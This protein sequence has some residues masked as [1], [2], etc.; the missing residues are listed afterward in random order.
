MAPDASG[1]VS[2]VVG[3]TA[4]RDDWNMGRDSATV[5]S[6]RRRPAANSAPAVM[7]KSRIATGRKCGCWDDLWIEHPVPTINEP[8]KAMC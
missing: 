1:R 4:N 8:H 3:Q 2:D 5:R 7:T 6:V